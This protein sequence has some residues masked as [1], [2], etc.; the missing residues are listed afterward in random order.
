MSGTEQPKKVT[1]GAFGRYLNEHRPALTKEL[2]GKRATEVVKLA[3]MRFKALSETEKAA[4]QKKYEEAAAQ[5]EKDMAAFLA[6]GGEKKAVERKRK[7][8]GDDSSPKKQKKEKDP[9][10]PKKPVG[11][12]FGCFLDENRAAFIKECAG[13]PAAAVCKL[14]GERW[15]QVSAKEK[16]RFDKQF[17][18]KKA[19]YNE[20]MKSYVPPPSAAPESEGEGGVAEAEEKKSPKQTDKAKGRKSATP[21]SPKLDADVAKQAEKAGMKEALEKLVARQDIIASGKSQAQM[22]KALQEN[23]GLIHP[24]KRALL[25]A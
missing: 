10:A 6:G 23:R 20:A 4:Y 21:A 17:E 7:S 2:A 1:G 13:K 8:D 14:A 19:A 5:Y 22:L 3:S 11:G 18:D 16:Q 15:K 9:D 25:G 12:A 24:S